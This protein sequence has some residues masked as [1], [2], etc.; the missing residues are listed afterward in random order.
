MLFAASDGAEARVLRLRQAISSRGWTAILGSL[1]LPLALIGLA[2]VISI[3]AIID[4][5]WLGGGLRV[6]TVGVVVTAQ[7]LWA[8]RHRFAGR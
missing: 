4:F 3:L 7:A 2:S 8:L 5:E 6:G 1:E